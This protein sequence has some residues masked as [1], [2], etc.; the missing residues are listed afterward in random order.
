MKPTNKS[1]KKSK[2]STNIQQHL[3]INLIPDVFASIKEL[4]KTNP[5]LAQKALEIL[6]YD[7]KKTHEEKEKIIEL[8]KNE[9]I[10]REK[11]IPFIRKYIFRG[12]FFAFVIGIS[13]LGASIYF[14]NIG[15]EKAA[16]T[17]IT[18]TLG[19]LAINF[20]NFKKTK[21]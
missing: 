11:E 12:Q 18:V 6:E 4:N 9:Q 21:L 1:E 7:L 8:E 10:L 16:I 17:S 5:K 3:N 13:G 2:P 19:V 15:M 14:G 20:I